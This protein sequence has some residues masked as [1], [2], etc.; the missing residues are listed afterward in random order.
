MMLEKVQ[1]QIIYSIQMY[2]QC[3]YLVYKMWNLALNNN[4]LH[5]DQYT[6]IDKMHFLF[7]LFKHSRFIDSFC[8][9]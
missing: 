9:L 3:M 7:N 6:S 2:T 4:G 1:I 5:T 8:S